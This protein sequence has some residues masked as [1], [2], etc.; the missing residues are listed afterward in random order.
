MG[1]PVCSS[2]TLK[3]FFE[4]VMHVS[5]TI[6]FDA[7]ARECSCYKTRMLPYDFHTTYQTHIILGLDK[8][9]IS[10]S[11]EK[12]TRKPCSGF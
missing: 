12:I 7:E 5:D 11:A 10:G 8:V 4:V 3:Q 2:R 1:T 9:N 6:R